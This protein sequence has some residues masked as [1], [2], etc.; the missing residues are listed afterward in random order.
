MN[1]YTTEKKIRPELFDSE[2]KQWANRLKH[3]SKAQFRRVYDEIKR[4]ERKTQGKADWEAVLPFVK[5]QKSKI[6]Y[7]V[8]RA[9]QKLPRKDDDK[10]KSY[11]ELKSFIFE[12][13]EAVK[14]SK[15]YEVFCQFFEAV[16]GFHYEIAPE[17]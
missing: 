7:T 15:D 8:T 9:K 5:M 3:V 4:L 11:D 6:S 10:R 17:K 13:V 12:G 2:A 1:F 14:S 16:Y